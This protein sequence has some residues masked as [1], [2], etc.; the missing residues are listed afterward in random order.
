VSARTFARVAFTAAIAI[1]A[2]WQIVEVGSA[3]A[4]GGHLADASSYR[5]AVDR[6]LSGAS[7]YGGEQLSGPHTMGSAVGGAGFVYPPP[8]LVL[9]LPLALGFGATLV[10]VLLT[11]A[12]FVGV[13]F[14]IARSELGTLPA[15]ASVV[16]VLAALAMP[17]L[18]E[19]LR[20]GNASALIATL[21]GAM[22]LLPRHGAVF[23]VVAG[24]IKVFPLIGAAWATRWESSRVPAI[25]VGL[26]LLTFS[27][28]VGVDRWSEWVIS[29]TTAVPSCPDWAL[30]SMPCATGS[31]LPGFVLAAVLGIGAIL[32][33]SRSIGF[34]LITVAMIVPAPD[35]Y[36]HYLLIPFVGAVPG[37]C[38]VVRRFVEMT[39]LRRPSRFAGSAV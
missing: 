6:W 10:W 8:A 20:F 34:L 23:A 36:Q 30:A 11:H 14:L 1:V 33:R 4:T 28:F 18:V 12:A 24:A 2:A 5:A 22:W 29:M 13:V 19:G 25:A 21:V 15:S 38:A 9:F 31:A 26:G 27:L 3:L 16:P 35:L 39:P 37:A 17:G 7:P 32:A